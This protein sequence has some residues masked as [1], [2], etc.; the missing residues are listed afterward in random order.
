MYSENEMSSLRSNST[1]ILPENE[2]PLTVESRAWLAKQLNKKLTKPM[3]EAEHIIKVPR[4][5]NQFDLYV[6]NTNAVLGKG[7]NSTIYEAYKISIDGDLDVSPPIAIK[8]VKSLAQEKTVQSEIIKEGQHAERLQ[9]IAG[10]QRESRALKKMSSGLVGDHVHDEAGDY[11]LMPLYPGK[12]LGD[13]AAQGDSSGRYQLQLATE[14]SEAALS[15][16]IE[17]LYRLGDQLKTLHDNQLMHGDLHLSNI[18]VGRNNDGK[19]N[20][21]II[22]LDQSRPIS[23]KNEVLQS[24]D[25][26]MAFFIKAPEVMQ[27][28]IGAPSDIYALALNYLF[29]LG[30]KDPFVPDPKSLITKIIRNYTE[31][32]K[33]KNAMEEFKNSPDVLNISDPDLQRKVISNRRNFLIQRDITDEYLDQKSLEFRKPIEIGELDAIPIEADGIP[34][35]EIVK[36]FI[37][38]MLNDDPNKRPV[39]DEV[40][41]FML[42]V[43]A[44]VNL[45]A[46]KI[47]NSVEAQKKWDNALKEHPDK[48]AEFKE[49]LLEQGKKQAPKIHPQPAPPTTS[50][51]SSIPEEY[52]E[53][54]RVKLDVLLTEMKNV[55]QQ[56]NQQK[57][58]IGRASRVLSKKTNVTDFEKNLKGMAG[59]YNAAHSQNPKEDY[60]KI[61]MHLI[62]EKAALGKNIDKTSQSKILTNIIVKATAADTVESKKNLATQFSQNVHGLAKRLSR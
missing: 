54:F 4:D 44:L 20:V 60:E 51:A 27:K 48:I 36:N 7:S 13:N 42:G 46:E 1:T 62:N 59:L 39:I 16:K 21:N 28:K 17:I 40:N 3:F 5:N 8:A 37:A 15:E 23:N 2:I 49:R 55:L 53:M 11:L 47:D 29:I 26:N 12:K 57:G 33:Y 9:T 32:D 22:D 45:P 25:I 6:L 14:V 61:M 41:Q 18:L 58:F 24:N 10:L 30:H 31:S 35:R 34:L 50:S 43:G 52:Q 38:S 19:L 56:V